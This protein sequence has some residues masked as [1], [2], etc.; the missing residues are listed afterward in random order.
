MSNKKGTQ[1]KN[2]QLNKKNTFAY[3]SVGSRVS[4]L[5]LLLLHFLVFFAVGIRYKCSVCVDLP[6]SVLQCWNSW[7]TYFVQLEDNDEDCKYLNEEWK[8]EP[9]LWIVNRLL[10]SKL[11]DDHGL[12]SDT[13]IVV[14]HSQT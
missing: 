3:H 7:K 4:G 8:M 2:G 10:I 1:P 6:C 5:S 12:C 11:S 14:L 9:K 13:L